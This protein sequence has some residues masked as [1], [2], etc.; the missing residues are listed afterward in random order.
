VNYAINATIHTYAGPDPA[1]VLQA[2]QAAAEAYVAA[3]LK[4]GRTISLSG[5]YA[6]LQ[7]PGVGR[8]E[9]VS[10]IAD[11]QI[12]QYQVGNCTGI[13]LTPGTIEP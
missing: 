4:I 9:L 2:C 5:V 13:D 6:A 3:S 7:Q 11:I 8:V 12:S 1:A 10:P